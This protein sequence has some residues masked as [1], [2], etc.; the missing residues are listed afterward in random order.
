MGSH[1]GHDIGSINDGTLREVQDGIKCLVKEVHSR[2]KEFQENI[3]YIKS[4]EKDK[5]RGPTQIKAE[6]N[7]K[8]DAL[9]ANLE[10]RRA[11]LLEQVNNAFTGDLKELWAQK[12][13]HETSILSLQ[14][15]ISFANRSLARTS[16]IELLVLCA[17]ITSR[18]KELTQLNWDSQST[19]QLEITR[20]E[21]SDEPQQVYSKLPQRAKFRIFTFPPTETKFKDEVGDIRK[22]INQPT[23]TI[24]P[25][26]APHSAA[27]GQE[28]V[29]RL[30]VKIFV[31]DREVVSRAYQNTEL[32][33]STNTS[34]KP[35][36]SRGLKSAYYMYNT[37]NLMSVE[38]AMGRNTWTVRFTPTQ[39]MN[40][41]ITVN[42]SG[43]FG[44]Q[45]LKGQWRHN[46]Q[47]V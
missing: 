42:A 37:S 40:Y 6:V 1:N 46:I 12:A 28:V 13:Y 25:D 32:Q 30:T 8:V 34:T 41:Y 33:A 3:E 19:E 2:L 21:F 18:F 5:T 31:N 4:V 29:I 23:L 9:I 10:A 24:T 22:V 35:H 17:Q 39:C 7:E 36:Y 44:Q 45:L 47:A 26:N 16:G 27:C 43:R 11:E 20:V 14:S 38:R 15:A